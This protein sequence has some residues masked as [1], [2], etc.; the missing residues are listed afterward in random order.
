MRV[1]L[2]NI[3]RIV[4]IIMIITDSFKDSEGRSLVR[5]H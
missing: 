2:A 1:A 4:D 3:L 5:K